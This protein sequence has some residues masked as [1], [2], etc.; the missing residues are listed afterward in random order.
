MAP[1]S[2][3]LECAPSLSK[4]KQ[5]RLSVQVQSKSTRRI[6][7]PNQAPYTPSP[8]TSTSSA[9]STPSRSNMQPP[10][11]STS[12]HPR[13]LSELGALDR[14]KS[15]DEA[16]EPREAQSQTRLRGDSGS[17]IGS[18]STE[19]TK[20]RR[21]ASLQL[22]FATSEPFGGLAENKHF[23]GSN[24]HSRGLDVLV[25]EDNPISQKVSPLKYCITRNAC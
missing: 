18:N 20:Q 12:H 1:L 23:V 13:R 5:R 21:H 14:V 3:A 7:D 24:V 2:Q 4:G 8:S 11:S 19:L 17:S 15:T 6:S 16:D 9:F 25:A 22:D 10:S